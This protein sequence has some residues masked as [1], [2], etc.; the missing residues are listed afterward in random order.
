MYTFMSLPILLIEHTQEW[1][2]QRKLKVM[3]RQSAYNEFYDI[4]RRSHWHAQIVPFSL[5]DSELVIAE[6]C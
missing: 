1:S 4:R 2:T 6:K 5:N 3:A